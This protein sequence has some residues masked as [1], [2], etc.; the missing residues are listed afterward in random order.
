MIDRLLI[1]MLR[2]YKRWLSPLLGPACRFHPTCSVYAMEAISRFGA[3]KGSWLAARRVV[4]CHPLHPGGLDPVPP[5]KPSPDRN[6][7]CHRH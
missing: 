6:A 2:G 5:A 1:L 7:E 4:R 3:I